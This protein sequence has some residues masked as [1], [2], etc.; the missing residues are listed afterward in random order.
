M[1]VYQDVPTEC[2]ISVSRPSSSDHAENGK[3]RN[4]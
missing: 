2:E 4:F 1:S 3:I